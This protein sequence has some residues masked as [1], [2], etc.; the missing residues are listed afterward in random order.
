MCPH[1]EREKW[2]TVSIRKAFKKN[3]LVF[4][5]GINRQS[6][7]WLSLDDCIW[8][9]SILRSKHALMPSLNQYRDLFRDTLQVLNATTDMLVT[10]LLGSLTDCPMED[11][12]DY[13]YVKEL[14]KEIARMRPKNRELE[15]L[16]DIE[17]WPC[18]APY[19][20][21][22]LCSIGYFYVN[23]RQD[24]FDIF[25]DSYTFLDFD[26]DTSKKV[27]D[28]LRKQGCELFLSE[29]VSIETESREPLE[30]DHDL[31]QDFRARA[32]A[33]VK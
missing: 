8:T 3:P 14:L 24:L 6:G 5:R 23:D 20:S 15:R 18:R 11:E 26:F 4:L 33:L 29:N 2:L 10:D 28:L 32:D 7:Q 22:E 19:C 31:T 21:R 9:R 30:Y 12:D 27:A 13:Q 25:S 17:C 1:L 16:D